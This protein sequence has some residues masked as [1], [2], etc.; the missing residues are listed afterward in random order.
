MKQLAH[1]VAGAAPTA[2]PTPTP[3]A[4]ATRRGRRRRRLAVVCTGSLLALLPGCSGGSASPSVPAPPTA[5]VSAAPPAAAPV[6]GSATTNGGSPLAGRALHA[7]PGVQAQ[8]SADGIRAERPAD[9][10]L[11]DRISRTPTAIWLGTWNATAEVSANVR[12]I[13]AGGR[14]AGATPVLAVYRLPAHDC[15]TYPT[16]GEGSPDAYRAW[17]AQVAAGLAPGPAAVILEPGV[18]AN[19]NCLRQPDVE[20]SYQLIREAAGVLTRAGTAVYLDIGSGA[21][22]STVEAARRLRLA[23]VADVRGFALNTSRFAPTETML[24]Y[25]EAVVRQLGT[26]TGF[27]VDTSRNGL[28]GAAGGDVCNPAGR[29]LGPLPTTNTGRAAADALL[30]IKMPGES[31]GTCN[32]GPQAG[33]FWVDY[34]VGLARRAGW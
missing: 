26:N 4:T 13:V 29:A 10:A 14:F 23:G 32:G 19:L 31:D 5:T 1:A 11:L 15:T 30:W 21:T 18:L 12:G 6:P 9:A 17:I 3:T 27:V 20:M 24:D 7:V 8:V 33:T 28:G 22:L 25:G 34:A 16:T 2:T